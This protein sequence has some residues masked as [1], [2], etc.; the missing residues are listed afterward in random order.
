[1]RGQV[2]MRPRM[3]ASHKAVSWTQGQGVGC[4]TGGRTD[5]DP[6]VQCTTARRWIL[7]RDPTAAES[8]AGNSPE[9]VTAEELQTGEL[10]WR[11]LRHGQ[12]QAVVVAGVLRHYDG[13][14]DASPPLKVTN[15]EWLVTVPWDEGERPRLSSPRGVAAP[16][17]R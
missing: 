13:A 6:L 12:G 14:D 5:L 15:D 3:C 17:E 10:Q 16:R 11:R 8:S 2:A 9:G 4:P 1:M 7:R